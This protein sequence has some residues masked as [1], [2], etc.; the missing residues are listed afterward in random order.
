[1]GLAT[2]FVRERS[3]WSSHLPRTPADVSSLGS[4]CD[5]QK[6]LSSPAGKPGRAP[7]A[8]CLNEQGGSPL[9]ASSAFLE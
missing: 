4:W 1:M 3:A 6:P 7:G 9:P 5:L 8:G 2:A